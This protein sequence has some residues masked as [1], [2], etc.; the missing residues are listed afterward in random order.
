MSK[1]HIM[2]GAIADDLIDKACQ[3][4]ANDIRDEAN[5]AHVKQGKW[6]Y[7]IR[8]NTLGIVAGRMIELAGED[9]HIAFKPCSPEILDGVAPA[10]VNDPVMPESRCYCIDA[11]DVAGAVMRRMID[12][13]VCL[14]V[15]FLDG[16]TPLPLLYMS[17]VDL[18]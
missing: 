8:E 5:A 4:A 6:C 1:V 3:D 11:L 13:I 7:T 9:S 15:I 17:S 2:K 16:V 12:G 18:V 10:E 14:L